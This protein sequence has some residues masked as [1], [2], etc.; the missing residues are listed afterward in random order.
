MSTKAHEA[1]FPALACYR[2]SKVNPV[3]S[4]FIHPL[5][6]NMCLIKTTSHILSPHVPAQLFVLAMPS[7]FKLDQWGRSLNNSLMRF[8]AW[9][10]YVT[11]QGDEVCY[12]WSSCQRSSCKPA[13]SCAREKSPCSSSNSFSFTV[14]IL[15]LEWNHQKQ[16]V[17]LATGFIIWRACCRSPCFVLALVKITAAAV[18]C[19]WNIYCGRSASGGSR[20]RSWGVGS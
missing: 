14:Y 2:Y 5:S 16:S 6:S 7:L 4:F 8:D 9:F 1:L 11:P 17:K 18:M 20:V 12:W 3:F 19:D 10:V 13:L 15:G